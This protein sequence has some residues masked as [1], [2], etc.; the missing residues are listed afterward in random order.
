V[1][2]EIA[3][4]SGSNSLFQVDVQAFGNGGV[5]LG[6]Y[7]LTESG[8]YGSGGTCS[9]LT[10]RP[11]VPCNDAP[12]VGFYDPEGRIRSIY[13][14]VCAVGAVC[15]PNLAGYAPI[16]FAIDSLLVDEIPEPAMPLLIGGGLAAILLYGRKRRSRAG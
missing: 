6:S 9:T 14:S 1:W 12:Y 3:A 4:L 10:G 7:T 16:G 5:S 2:F 8:A 11:P 15:N 13:I